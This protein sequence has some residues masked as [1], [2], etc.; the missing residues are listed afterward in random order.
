MRNNTRLILLAALLAV[1]GCSTRP[2]EFDARLSAPPADGQSYLRDFATCRLLVRSNFRKNTG[3]QAAAA[4]A[5]VPT[6]FVGGLFVSKIIKSDR[7]KRQNAQMTECLQKYG[8]AVA[9]WDRV[10]KK[11]RGTAPTPPV[12]VAQTE[13]PPVQPQNVKEPNQ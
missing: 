13:P 8:Y 6:Y 4:V 2:G 9:G 5:S 12:A 3:Q 10:G 7:E 1:G 11:N